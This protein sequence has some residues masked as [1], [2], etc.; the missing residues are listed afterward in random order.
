MEATGTD[1]VTHNGHKPIIEPYYLQHNNPLLKLIDFG[2]YFDQPIEE[3]TLPSSLTHLITGNSFNYPIHFLPSSLTHLTFGFSFNK[4][5]NNTLPAS[6]THLSF[7]FNFNQSVNAL[8]PSLT[9]L[10]F[11]ESFNQS[12]DFLPCSLT[13]LTLGYAFNQKPTPDS[14]DYTAEPYRHPQSF[15]FSGDPGTPPNAPIVS[16]NYTNFRMEKP[17]SK[18]WSEVAEMVPPNPESCCLFDSDCPNSHLSK[19]YDLSIYFLGLSPEFRH[20]G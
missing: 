10:S 18:M 8:P 20:L 19:G 13:H 14:L 9:H 16:Q 2:D 11:I 15:Y 3:G 6:L 7:G 4:A 5:V 17:D 1:V 12:I